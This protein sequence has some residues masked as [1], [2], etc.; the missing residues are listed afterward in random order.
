MSG[1]K[2]ERGNKT[3]PVRVTDLSL[4]FLDLPSQ[5]RHSCLGLLLDAVPLSLLLD[6]PIEISQLVPVFGPPPFDD[7]ELRGEFVV[8]SLWHRR[9]ERFSLF[10][11]LEREW[12]A[13][14]SRENRGYL[15]GLARR[16]GRSNRAEAGVVVVVVVVDVFAR[17]PNFVRF[18][19]SYRLGASARI[20]V[21]LSRQARRR[22]DQRT[23]PSCRRG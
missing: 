5:L 14:G 16:F 11:V 10:G 20:A 7:R 18:I 23:R 21:S 12:I 22:R 3:E 2:G 15:N 4:E 9:F 17:K 8:R 13:R 1:W 6:Q 19:F